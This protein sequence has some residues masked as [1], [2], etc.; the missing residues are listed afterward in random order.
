[1]G[2]LVIAVSNK[3]TEDD[4][5]YTLVSSGGHIN[6]CSWASCSHLITVRVVDNRLLA[7]SIVHMHGKQHFAVT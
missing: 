5:A 2:K 7:F 4:E 6:T 3:Q 1:V